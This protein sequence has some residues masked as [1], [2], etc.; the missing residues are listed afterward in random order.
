MLYLVFVNIS[1]AFAKF[2]Y[3]KCNVIFFNNVFIVLTETWFSD[4]Y[5]NNERGLCNYNIFRLDGC[6]QS[7]SCRGVLIAIRND[8]PT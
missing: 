1:E 3:V 7:S 5:F 4:N 8:I 6:S 2:K